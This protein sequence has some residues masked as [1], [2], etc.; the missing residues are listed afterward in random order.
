MGV[1]ADRGPLGERRHGGADCANGAYTLGPNGIARKPDPKALGKK[2][3]EQ[4]WEAVE[5]GLEAVELGLEAIV[6]GLEAIVLGLEAIVLGLEAVE[7][8]LEAIV[9]GLEAVELRLGAAA[10]TRAPATPSLSLLF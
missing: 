4:S 8:R 7:L 10:R 5:L 1:I 3:L 6:L 2:A 9:L